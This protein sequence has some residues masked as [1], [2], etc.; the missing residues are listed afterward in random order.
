VS[1][2]LHAS[3]SHPPGIE[4]SDSLDRSLGV[5]QSQCGYCEEEKNLRP[6]NPTPVSQL[7]SLSIVI[8]PSEL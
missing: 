1:Y 7:A 5:S 6:R 8:M 2:Q 3:A 4:P